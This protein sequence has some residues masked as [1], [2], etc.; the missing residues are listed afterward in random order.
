MQSDFLAKVHTMYNQFTKAEKKVADFILQNP[1]RVL[2]MSITELADECKV[3]D[4]SVFRFCRTMGVKGYQEF[5]MQLSLS[6][7]DGKEEESRLAG[8]TSLEDSFSELAKKVLN[9]N[10]KALAETY[11]LLDEKV[12]SQTVDIL[13]AAERIWFFGVG[14]SLLVALKAANKFLRIEPKV[15]CVQDTHT[16]A[17]IAATM[18]PGEAAVVFSYPAGSEERG[19]CYQTETEMLVKSQDE[20]SG[21][22]K[23]IVQQ[24]DGTK[25]EV[26]GAEGSVY[27]PLGYQGRLEAYAVD[28]AGLESVRS[29]SE[30]IICEDE[31][32]L[33]AVTGA[34]KSGEWQKDLPKIRLWIGERSEKYTCSA[35]LRLAV[36]YVNG[37]EIN[38]K[39][40]ENP[41]ESD[42]FTVKLEKESVDGSPVELM[43]HAV[44]RA[45]NSTV[46]KEKLYI[47]RKSPTAE[48][49]GVTDA[50][51]TGE[52]CSGEIV[53]K[54][55]NLLG[56]Y[57]V[58]VTR[59]DQEKKKELILNQAEQELSEKEVS[60]PFVFEEDG[61]YEC[62]IQV[63]D[64]AGWK[65]EKEYR[66][67]IDRCSPVIRYVDQLN[68]TD[69]PFF[70]WNYEVEE[71]VSDL[72]DYQYQMLLDGL[73]YAKG[74]LV[75]EEGVHR[76]RV[77]AEDA[78]GND[79]VAEAVF[80]IDHTPPV[81]YM[82]RLKDGAIY[83]EKVKIEVWV[84]GEKEYL[85]D[86]TLNGE[87]QKLSTESRMFQCEIMESGNYIMGV[88]AEDAAGNQV[89]KVI[90]FEIRPGKSIVQKI[91]KPVEDLF[92]GHGEETENKMDQWIWAEIFGAAG[93]LHELHRKCGKVCSRFALS[94]RSLR[95]PPE[96]IL[97]SPV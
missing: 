12:V 17:M 69:L 80:T 18:R 36:C 34:G 45:G 50:M 52:K 41:T 27:L 64:R 14:A 4:T 32:P 73:E 76:L 89:K 66:F 96:K 56:K 83:E 87:R 5:K 35:G 70:Q 15:Y 13:H 2:F 49:N 29:S 48:M 24:E 95:R 74:R 8:E 97:I 54:D 92:S 33:I 11:S 40:Y 28:Y 90:R 60:I 61:H 63:E 31:K 79:S 84:D 55:E 46:R 58:S 78:A 71:A 42:S 9:T 47:D 53:L 77:R 19:Y 59:T 43:V 82:G 44:D 68:G 81:L 30:Q 39:Y 21:V 86:L 67:V 93:I 51:I 25:L 65:T 3:G 62:R 37:E 22:E 20:S 85:T 57:E 6:I 91:W 10:M 38:R 1:K 88:Q 7:H 26:E 72:T 75:T 23:I 94:V 16:Q